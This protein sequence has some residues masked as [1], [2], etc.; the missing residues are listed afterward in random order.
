M[1]KLLFVFS[2]IVLMAAGCGSAP[3]AGV[4]NSP[5]PAQQSQNNRQAAPQ[6]T[7]PQNQPQ[8]APAATD[9]AVQ[10]KD[11]Y[12]DADFQRIVGQPAKA[13]TTI[14]GFSGRLCDITSNAHPT[15]DNLQIE[16]DKSGNTTP[17]QVYAIEC[18][19]ANNYGKILA[20]DA[21]GIG[22]GACIQDEGSDLEELKVLNT[23]KKFFFSVHSFLRSGKNREVDKA[24]A[25]VIDANLGKY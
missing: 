22:S 7:T 17:E 13:F 18:V 23:N 6:Q 10:C 1:K 20:V 16:I 21:P 25:L 5:T 2:A 12:T 14:V 3:Q 8:T 4:Q 24:M 19:H 15:E 11:L 9:I